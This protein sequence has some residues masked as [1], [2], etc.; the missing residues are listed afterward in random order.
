MRLTIMMPALGAAQMLDDG[1][2]WFPADTAADT[3]PT[4]RGVA[5]RAVRQVVTIPEI[6]RQTGNIIRC[7]GGDARVS[8]VAL[9]KRK[10]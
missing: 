2:E 5:L 1:A 7:N 6:T 10:V 9:Q 4:P 3:S 8:K